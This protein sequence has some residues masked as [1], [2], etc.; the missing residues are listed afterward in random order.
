MQMI[1]GTAAMT[2]SAKPLSAKTL[3][4][5]TKLADLIGVFRGANKTLELALDRVEEIEAKPVPAIRVL[6]GKTDPVTLVLTNRGHS[7]G[8]VVLPFRRSDQQR[9][10]KEPEAIPGL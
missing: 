5:S 9:F 10:G 7:G 6:G 3:A 2:A 4:Q 8:G 1:V